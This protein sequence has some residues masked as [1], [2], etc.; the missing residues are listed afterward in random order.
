MSLEVVGGIKANSLAI[1]TDAA[2]L[3]SDVAGFAISLF[4]IW[5]SGWEATPRQTFGF[6][7][8]EILAFG[9]RKLV[10]DINSPHKLNIVVGKD[11]ITEPLLSGIEC[12]SDEQ[13]GDFTYKWRNVDN[14]NLHG[15]TLRLDEDI[16]TGLRKKKS[17]HKNI[18]VEGAY[19]HVLGD[20]IQS[21]GV[22]IGGACIWA[23]PEWRIIDLICTLFFSVLVLITTINMLRNI[24]EVLMESTPREIDATKLEEGLMEISGVVAVH[25]LHIWAITVGKILLAC[26]VRI[27]SDANADLILQKVIDYC[28]KAYKISHVTV[29]IERDAN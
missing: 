5:A 3:F 22:M 11:T 4:A 23:K 2:H 12:H 13:E 6:Y 17:P 21:I 20:L 18:N 9:S 7:R 16:E 10:V 8:L 14:K 29:Q 15:A 19:L 28:D 26:H 27:K 24:L 25:E 1:L